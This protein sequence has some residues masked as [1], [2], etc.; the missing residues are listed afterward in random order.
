[1]R[2]PSILPIGISGFPDR[3]LEN[4]IVRRCPSSSSSCVQPKPVSLLKRLSPGSIAHHASPEWIIPSGDPPTACSSRYLFPILVCFPD[5]SL[6]PPSLSSVLS[7]RYV[8]QFRHVANFG[9]AAAAAPISAYCILC[10]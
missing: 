3:R 6:I 1:M 2:F 5:V 10:S 8:S 4:T 9:F 7:M